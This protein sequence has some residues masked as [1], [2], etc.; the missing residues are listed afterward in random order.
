MRKVNPI[1]IHHLKRR[2][3]IKPMKVA[4]ALVNQV[5]ML[6]EV[7]ILMKGMQ[8]LQSAQLSKAVKV[9]EMKPKMKQ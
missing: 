4:L 7:K 9:A 8:N 1:L 2:I 6:L 5:K 3:I